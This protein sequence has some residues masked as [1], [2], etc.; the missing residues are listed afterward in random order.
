MNIMSI[1]AETA[2]PVW[3]RVLRGLVP[4]LP[5]VSLGLAQPSQAALT[6]APITWNVVGLDSNNVNAGP[7]EFLVGVRVTNTAA[8]PTTTV[9]TQFVWDTTNTLVNIADSLTR[10]MPSIPAGGSVDV[11]FLCVVTRSASAHNTAR[12]YHITASAAG[13]STVSTPTPR[14]IFVEKLVSQSRNSVGSFSGSTSVFLGN[15]YTYTINA[16][17]STNGYDQLVAESVFPSSIFQIVSINQTYTAPPGATNNEFYADACG[18]QNDPTQPNYKGC[19]GP[20]QYTG[21]KA[22][23][24]IVST[25]QVRIVGTGTVTVQTII[26]DFSG[27]SYHYNADFGNS[28]AAKTITA[29]VET[30][31]MTGHLFRDLNGNGVQDPGEPNL[32]GVSVNITDSTGGVSTVVTDSSGNYSRSVPG[33]F[34]DCCSCGLDASGGK[35]PDHGQRPAD[36]GGSRKRNGCRH[37]GWLP[38]TRHGNRP[39]LQRCQRQWSSG[40]GGD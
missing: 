32:S 18:W 39:H 2:K 27:S 21:G 40:S 8:T 17:T 37:P 3:K 15:T 6:I 23:G 9:T 30:G 7:N 38:A 11:N 24:D 26:Y 29:T 33:R 14:E 19:S 22:G 4:L 36:R 10:T 28:I 34:G 1:C 25:V 31:T 16:S 35:H 12:R 13:V 5:L 20:A